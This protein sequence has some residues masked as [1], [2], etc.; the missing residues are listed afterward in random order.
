MTYLLVLLEV[1][2][3][4]SRRPLKKPWSSEWLPLSLDVSP[5]LT[6]F[7]NLLTFWPWFSSLYLNHS[8]SIFISQNHP[9]SLHPSEC[10]PSLSN[11]LLLAWH[12]FCVVSP[13][14]VSICILSQRLPTAHAFVLLASWPSR[15]LC[16]KSPLFILR[17]WD[18]PSIWFPQPHLDP[19]HVVL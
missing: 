14:K 9:A 7:P 1:R 6:V 4:P 19:G 3:D 15:V 17:K 13:Y 12:L 8:C 5:R 11:D 18:I 16:L 10:A 2:P